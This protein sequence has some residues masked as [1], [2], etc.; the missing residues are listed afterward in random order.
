MK[1][2]SREDLVVGCCTQDSGTS[3]YIKGWNF[4][5]PERPLAS[6]KGLLSI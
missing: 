5:P 6:E 1:T 2:T 4:C 3:S